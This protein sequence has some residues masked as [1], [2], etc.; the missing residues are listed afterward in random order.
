MIDYLLMAFVMFAYWELTGLFVY[1]WMHIRAWIERVDVR[2]LKA[3]PE[4]F[5]SC[6]ILGPIMIFIVVWCEI[7][8]LIQFIKSRRQ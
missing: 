8:G 3:Y 7:K 5:K 2:Q 1:A 6:L 4:F